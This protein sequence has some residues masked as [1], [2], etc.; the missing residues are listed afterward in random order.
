MG[1]VSPQSYFDRQ[2]RVTGWGVEGQ[3][4]L[5]Q[6]R[7]LIV[8]LGGLGCPAASA[9]ARAGV[10]GLILADSDR[11]EASNLPR[12]TLFTLADC[13]E[14]KVQVARR[15]LTLV[16]PWLTVETT[17]RVDGLQVRQLVE[18]VDLVIEGSDN[19][20]TKFLIHDA[21]RAA[22]K[23]LVLGALYQWECLTT[24][25]RFD[26]SPSPCWRCLYPEQPQDGCVGVCSDVGVAGALSGL[27]GNFLGLVATRLLLGHETVEGTTV[28][29]ATDGTTRTL[30]WQTRVDCRCAK[31][32]GDWSWLETLPNGLAQ[33]KR[34]VSWDSLAPSQ[35]A[36]VVD[37]RE[38]EEIRQGDWAWFEGQGS[39][40]IHRPWSQWTDVSQVWDPETSYLLVCT[41]GLRSQK[42]LQTLPPQ[43]R[44]YS[45]SG[46]LQSLG[47][48]SL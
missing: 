14:S 45:L 38:H 32:R 34:S 48:F 31:A 24:T 37:L 33:Q 17:G 19:L 39:L 3:K 12:Q 11:V 9:L 16:N 1:D 23:P 13:G 6:A 8:G 10:G 15:A 47:A 46:G 44:A 29:D 42:A 2:M 21:C 40:V 43:Q 30:K 22:G 35:R 25:F 5:A 28:F 36:V 27:A 18:N 7:V 41:K 26:R 4:R 20:E